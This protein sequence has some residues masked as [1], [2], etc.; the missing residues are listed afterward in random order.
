MCIRDSLYD[1]LRSLLRREP[2]WVTGELEPG[3]TFDPGARGVIAFPDG[4][5]AYV[6]LS[7]ADPTGFEIDVTGTEGRL[8]AGNAL[9][10]EWW[11][12]DRSGRRPAWVRRTFPGGHDGRSAMLR[13][14]EDLLH[15]AETGRPPLSSAVD[16]RADLEI[17]VAFHLAHRTGAR[18]RFP[19]TDT[20]YVIEDPWGRAPSA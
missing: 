10:P 19:I 6:N 3:T 20:A 13:A 7:E 17:A 1:L 12:V 16:A 2:E 15:S 18:I 9:Y 8:R 14:V 11:Q 4:I 5:R